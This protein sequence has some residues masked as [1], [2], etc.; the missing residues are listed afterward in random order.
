VS[1]PLC[2]LL[3]TDRMDCTGVNRVSD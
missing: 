1:Y 3:M 2:R